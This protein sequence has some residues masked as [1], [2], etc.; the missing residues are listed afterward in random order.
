MSKKRFITG[1]LA[2]LTGVTYKTIRHYQSKGLIS[3]EEYT[4][5]GYRLYGTKAVE[6]L[7]RILMLKYLNFSLEDIQ[8]MITDDDIYNDFSRQEELLQAQKDHLEQ[9]LRA[10]KD[11]QKIDKKKRWNEMLNI[12]NMTQQKEEIIKQYRFSDNL[13]KRINIHN[14]ST[15]NIDWFSWV[16]EG[17]ELK[18]GM[19][20]L[21]IGCGTG[22]LWSTLFDK[23]PNCLNIHLTDSSES[24]LN[25]TKTSIDYHIDKF[26]SKN[27]HFTYSIID[28]EDPSHINGKYDRIIANHMLYHISN[29]ARHELFETFYRNLDE[30]GMLYASTVGKDHLKELS[31]LVSNFDSRID[32][33]HSMTENFELENG[34]KQ[35]EKVFPK[36]MIDVHD[37]DLIVPDPTAVYDYIWSWPGNVKEIL[38]GRES[39]LM[40]YLSEHISSE[41]PYFI[42]K[43]TGA[44]RAFK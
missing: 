23:L 36:V 26:K 28:G 19:T 34:K 37:N 43:S 22:T 35:L 13:E 9:I 16:L 39:D 40:D 3:P 20:I 12:I 31:E 32:N 33:M 11:I 15:S 44:F 27:I 4:E 25:K 24:M 14:Y 17:L 42:H 30:N 1:E 8:K 2:K 38:R 7:Q 6:T 10:V 21:E 29:V 18:S 5:S 41:N